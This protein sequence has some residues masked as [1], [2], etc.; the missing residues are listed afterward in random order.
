MSFQQTV[1][2]E[3]VMG[4]RANSTAITHITRHV[5]AEFFTDLQKTGQWKK[6][7]YRIFYLN[8]CVRCKVSFC[9]E[10]E[11]AT[12]QIKSSDSNLIFSGNAM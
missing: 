9:H 1:S 10:M 12:V 7:L 6:K 8:F 4:Q 2:I 11:K 5:Q 3:T